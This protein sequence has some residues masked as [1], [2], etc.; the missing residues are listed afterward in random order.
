MNTTDNFENLLVYVEHWL[1]NVLRWT[2][3]LMSRKLN[4]V[5]EISHVNLRADERS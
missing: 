4:E 3:M 1:S 5:S 2:E